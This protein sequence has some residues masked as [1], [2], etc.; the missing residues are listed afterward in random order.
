MKTRIINFIKSQYLSKYGEEYYYRGFK[1]DKK[2]NLLDV[3]DNP[4][5]Y[6]EPTTER[7][8]E[9]FTKHKVYLYN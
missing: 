4:K 7:I 3:R 8:I 1:I 9:F 2:G 5:G 6:K